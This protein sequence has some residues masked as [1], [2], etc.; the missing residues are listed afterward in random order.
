LKQTPPS[1]ESIKVNLGGELSPALRAEA[2]AIDAQLRQ[3]SR[4][5]LERE[6]EKLRAENA[7]LKNAAE[8]SNSELTEEQKRSKR[9]ADAANAARVRWDK[10][11][12]APDSERNRGFTQGPS[13]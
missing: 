2:A 11:E 8:T 9:S 13:A 1:A 4:T 5:D 7:D 6:I 10:R 3:P 12:Q